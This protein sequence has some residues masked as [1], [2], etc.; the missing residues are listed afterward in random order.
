MT[1]TVFHTLVDVIDAGIE[2]AI[3]PASARFGLTNQYLAAKTRGQD[4]LCLS[5]CITLTIQP[6]IKSHWSGAANPGGR[7]D[8]VH[9]E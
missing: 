2:P 1:K 4:S 6:E 5:V 7:Q 9:T 3:T 8:A